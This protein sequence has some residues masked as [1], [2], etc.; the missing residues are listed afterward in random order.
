MNKEL[1]NTYIASAKPVIDI[2][3]SAIENLASRLNENFEK[4]KALIK[5]KR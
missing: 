3:A 2:E 1:Q 4:A 5:E